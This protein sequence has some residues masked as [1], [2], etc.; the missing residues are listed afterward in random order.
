NRTYNSYT[1]PNETD[2]Y[3]QDHYQFI[4]TGSLGNN[5]KVNGALH[6]TVGQGY[7]E[8]FREDDDL[9]DYNLSPVSIGNETIESTDIIRRRWLDNDFYGG[10][11]SFN[12]VSDNG[13]WD[14][15]MGGGANRYDGYPFGEIICTRID[16]HID[17]R[18]T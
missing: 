6:Y 5:W 9:E 7:Y 15:L 1:Y 10:V 17:I 16:G 14:L 2:N 12:Y 18:H 4:Y 13:R 11:F 3:K 8:Q